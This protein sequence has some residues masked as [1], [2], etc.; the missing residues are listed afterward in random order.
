MGSS[1][2]I[3]KRQMKTYRSK[4]GMEVKGN[5]SVY[6]IFTDFQ[7]EF[8]N[9][10]SQVDYMLAD[11]RIPWVSLYDHLSLTAGI[12]VTMTKELLSRGRSPNNICG[13]DLPENELRALACLCGFIHDIGK[14]RMGE[15]KYY[16]HVQ[17]GIK[18]AQEWLESKNIQ[19]HLRSVILNA[20]G[21]HHL[22]DGPQTILEQVICLADSYASAGDRPELSKAST[23][24]ELVQT[25]NENLDLEHSLFGDHKPLCFLL[26][27][28]D[29]IKEYIYETSSLPEIRGASEILLSLDEKV[30][31]LFREHLAAESLIYCGGGGFLAIVPASQAEEWQEHIEALYLKETHIATITVVI[32]EPVGYMD[33]G[34]GLIPYDDEQVRKLVG[35]GI[36]GDLLFS[37]FEAL[38]QNR[39][40]RKN[41][42]E[43][44][45]KLSS[46]LQ[47]AKRQKEE[48]SFLEALPIYSRCHSCGKR[49]SAKQDDVKAEWLCDLCYEKRC[50]GR[51][52][53]RVFVRRF[54]EWAKTNKGV[55]IPPKNSEGKPRFPEDLDAL[56]GDEGRIAFLYVDGNNMGDLLQ[57]MPSPASY[58]HFSQVLHSAISD[59][60]FSA[61]WNAFGE[62]RLRNLSLPFEII[63]LGGDDLVAIVPA[64]CGWALAV[65]VLEEFE[66]NL[67]VQKLEC[68]L[69]E[70]LKDALLKA[71]HLSLSAGLAIADVKYP[72]RFLFDLA[73]GLLKEAKRL[74]RTTQNG[75]I[76]HLWL[77]APVI[78]ESAKVLMDELYKR[79]GRY[80][81]ARPYTKDQAK[82]L[83]GIAR[84]LST[85]ATSQRKSLAESIEKGI[86]VSLNYALYQA[87]RIDKDKQ[88]TIIETFE[89]LGTFM[90]KNTKSQN[91]KKFWFWQEDN[92]DKG[93]QTALLDALELIELGAT[94]V[95]YGGKS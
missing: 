25:A 47:Q 54:I 18:Y 69:N 92:Q 77:R 87:A 7:Q 63:A 43:V 45:A 79:E 85:L 70:R 27:D 46:Q 56:A 81:T 66:K 6:R 19:N 49:A 20:I 55:E 12:A 33:I 74:A 90:S 34:R 53:R 15:T 2:V 24:S 10:L 52:G 42:G 78:S 39:A 65:Q 38:L 82:E 50:N 26:G 5:M 93:W 73:E 58:R 64:S 36:A 59:A 41:F 40:R 83:I 71:A 8:S 29:A 67:G 14:A 72:V 48:A 62:A 11:T 68:E 17:E 28:T 88:E 91:L 9:R 1:Y 23:V 35:R 13:I 57:L 84:E 44:V 31:E 61:F 4:I 32:S 30:R 51:K 80:L 89:K 76:C 95:G 94:K 3:L 75:T 60:L 16:N 21:R 37:H 22:R 86:H